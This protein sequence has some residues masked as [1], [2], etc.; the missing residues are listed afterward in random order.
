MFSPDRALQ[1]K[2]LSVISRNGLQEVA[3]GMV[4]PEN[5]EQLPAEELHRHLNIQIWVYVL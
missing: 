5:A 3:D 2:A 1:M 4:M